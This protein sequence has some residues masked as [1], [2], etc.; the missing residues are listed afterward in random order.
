MVEREGKFPAQ[1]PWAMSKKKETIAVS[2]AARPTLNA[3]MSSIPSATWCW[4]IAPRR[5][6]SA[7]GQGMSP[8]E[9]PMATRPRMVM[10][11]WW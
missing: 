2:V 9:A 10:S 1:P 4:E 8:A 6:T 7:E 5:T 11:W 3:T